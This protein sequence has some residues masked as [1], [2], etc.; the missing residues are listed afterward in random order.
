MLLDVL[1]LSLMR[2]F[3]LPHR[4]DSDS[5]F[6]KFLHIVV[7]LQIFLQNLSLLWTPGLNLAAWL[8]YDKLWR[9]LA[10]PSLDSLLA[11]LSLLLDYL[12]ISVIVLVLMLT[13]IILLVIFTYFDKEMPYV[14]RQALR[15]LMFLFSYLYFIPTTIVL[16]ILLKYSGSSTPTIEEYYNQIP[17]TQFNYGSIGF[18][19]AVILLGL[20]L[21]FGL[22][23]ECFT[24][25]I[26]HSLAGTDSR[27]KSTAKFDII[28]KI[29]SFSRCL[30][31]TLVA[32][33]NYPLYLLGVCLLYLIGAMLLLY[34]LPNYSNF[35][36]F[37]KIQIQ[38]GTFA[39][40][41]IFLLGYL[42]NNATVIFVLAV[43]IEPAIC[44]LLFHTIKYRIQKITPVQQC[45]TP[46][47]FQFEVSARSALVSGKLHY[48]ILKIMNKN[49]KISN[50]KSN[51]VLQAHYCGDVLDQP[52]LGLLKISRI[53][54]YGF[55]IPAN[56]QVFKCKEE[57]QA[58]CMKASDGLQ[59]YNYLRKLRKNLK[60][61]NIYAKN[62]LS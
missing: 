22:V 55:D 52:M 1:Y 7:H 41:L 58:I 43:F 2:G 31:F 37:L 12:I 47:F 51:L 5:N 17:S 61:D 21:G 54:H 9:V 49:Y 35:M 48:D 53:N 34:Y 38:L 11:E 19:V 33:L 50:D 60:D 59:L 20:H 3:Q 36:N 44:V 32:N 18:F 16:S 15:L 45:F 13:L 24:I 26:K 29:L 10:Y 57:L 8:S 39:G 62:C 42:L 27:A 14:L 30:L 23:Y 40:S 25:E 6:R 46:N 28:I 56:F 4:S